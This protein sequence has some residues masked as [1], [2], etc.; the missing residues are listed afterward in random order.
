MTL[1]AETGAQLV[2]FRFSHTYVQNKLAAAT[3]ILHWGYF[4]YVLM[5][6]PSRFPDKYIPRFV[7]LVAAA[8]QTICHFWKHED[9]RP[10][11]CANR[12][13]IRTNLGTFLLIL[14]KVAFHFFLFGVSFSATAARRNRGA[15]DG[16]R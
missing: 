8:F 15:V 7:F 11:N 12:N 3:S 1:Q 2:S 13:P 9:K 10:G 6:F 5:A 4:R 14:L 16:Y